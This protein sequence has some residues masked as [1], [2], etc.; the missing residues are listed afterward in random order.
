MTKYR[1]YQFEP[2][3][4]CIIEQ[5]NM[6]KRCSEKKDMTEWN[7]WRDANPRVEIHLQGAILREANLRGARLGSANLQAAN[8]SAGKLQGA[9]LE[10]ADLQGAN[11]SGAN[12]QSARLSKANLEG[13]E[14]GGANLRGAG[15]RGANLQH[16]DLSRANLQGAALRY[17][18]LQDARLSYANLQRADLREANVQGVN[19][20]L[21]N[22]QG[23]DLSEANLQGAVL[24]EASLQGADLSG[25]DVRATD[26]NMAAVDGETIIWRD[27]IDKD[28]DFTG[29]GLDSARVPPGLKQLLKYNIRRIGWKE[30]YKKHPFLRWPVQFFWEMSDY[31]N[32]TWR[33]IQSLY[34]C[35]VFFAGMYL[36]VG[37]G[38]YLLSDGANT[39]MIENL[40]EKD[41]VVV[42]GWLVPWRALYFS[43]VTMTT[44]GFGD[45]YARADSLG[46]HIILAVQVLLGYV[47][48][49]ALVT[50][51]AVL[52]QA[53]GPAADFAERKTTWERVK[54]TLRVDWK[55][56]CRWLKSLPGSN[57]GDQEDQP[58]GGPR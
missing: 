41:G 44:L 14:L 45:I 43:I 23:A 26:F 52:F 38:C 8:L 5:Y 48:L 12:M 3:A 27:H 9:H 36:F 18:N 11:L 57:K 7:D 31:G 15:L 29:V 49:A 25:A 33:I 24:Q 4:R 13:A 30:W 22:L 32:S 17:A 35:A 54:Q 16:T 21:T 42:P 28:T 2:G 58:R 37:V 10:R 20:R 50:H 51:F 1:E 56:L 40:F 6:L 34:C 46:G 55:L 39:G 19:L 47:L 53:G